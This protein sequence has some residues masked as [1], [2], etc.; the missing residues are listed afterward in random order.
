M[1]RKEPEMAKRERLKYY[2]AGFTAGYKLA[3]RDVAT[4]LDDSEHN[5]KRRYVDQGIVDIQIEYS[6]KNRGKEV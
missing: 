6:D 1:S 2:E 5:A 4:L 3:M